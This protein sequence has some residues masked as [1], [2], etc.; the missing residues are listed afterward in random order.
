MGQRELTGGVVAR[1]ASLAVT[2]AMLEHHGSCLGFAV[3]EPAHINIWPNRLAER[4]L[5]TGSWIAPLKEA[6][7]LGLGDEAPIRLADGSSARLGNLRELVSVGPGQKLAYVTDVADTSANRT[8]IAQ[9]A[10]DAD[11][12]F[13]ESRFA[14]ADG[15]LADLRAH[16]TTTAAGEIARMSGARRVEPFHFSPRYEG[17][18]AAMLAEVERAF[19]VEPVFA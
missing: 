11:T 16:L 14:A 17:K 12:L 6:L 9:L 8:A 15:E 18:E 10:R 19:C 4:G 2:A 3:A 13:I 5:T 1:D 7:R